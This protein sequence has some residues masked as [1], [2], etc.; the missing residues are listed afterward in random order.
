MWFMHSLRCWDAGLMDKF[1]AAS[2]KWMVDARE[3]GQAQSEVW[4]EIGGRGEVC[5]RV[6]IYCQV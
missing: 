5:E 6:Q 3:L 1:I 4:R 2:L